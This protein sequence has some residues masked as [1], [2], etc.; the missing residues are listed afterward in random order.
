[1]RKALGSSIPLRVVV[2]TRGSADEFFAA[3]HTGRSLAAF[4]DTSPVEVRL[5]PDNSL[6]LST[7]YND[8][9]EDVGGE[10]RLM[11]FTHDDCLLADH[12]W[13]ERVRDGLADYDVIGVVGNTR[14]LPRQ[15]GWIV[16]DAA[17]GKL[18]DF[19]YLSG[20]IGQGDAFPPARLEYFGPPGRECKLMDG[21]FLAVHSDTLRRSGLRF[22]DTFKFHFYDM[23]FCRTAERLGLRMGTIPLSLVHASYGSMGPAWMEAYET[24][25][26]KWTE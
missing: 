24:Y 11:V 1:M 8:A 20:A 7:V 15:P 21:V 5:Y 2:A 26:R 14:R 17:S 12:Y 6:G 3:T 22:D 4:R 9:I 25:L 23:D 19:E 16:T 18:D 13:A 10:A